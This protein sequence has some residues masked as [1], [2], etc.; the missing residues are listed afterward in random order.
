MNS[1][2]PGE[3]QLTRREGRTLLGVAR[4]TI[5]NELGIDHE[6][7]PAGDMHSPVFGSHRGTFVTLKQKGNL[8]GCIGSLTA[9]QSL[10]ENIRTNALNAAFHDPR[11]SPLAAIEWDQIKIEISILTPPRKLDFAS[12]QDLPG[13]LTPHQDGVVIRRGHASATFLPQVWHQLP[14]AEDFLAHLCLKA[15]L[16]AGAWRRSDLEVETYRVQSFSE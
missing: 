2:P 3:Q 9:D 12:G 1:T 7:P 6:A 10:V 11:F 16:A 15:G 5:A 8:R 4:Q 13:L 14:R